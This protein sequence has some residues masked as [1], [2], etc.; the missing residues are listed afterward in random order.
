MTIELGVALVSTDISKYIE[1]VRALDRAGIGMIGCGDSQALYHE[2]FIRCALAAEHSQQARVG[3]WITNPRT[4]H[5]A[6]TAS[7]IATIDDIAPK[8]TFLGVGTGDSTVYNVGMKPASL[9]TLSDFVQTIRELH[10]N[11]KSQWQNGECYLTW[12]KRK[13]PIGMAPSGP[14]GFRLAGQIADIVWVCFGIEQDQIRLAKEYIAEG[15]A[16]AGRSLDDIDLWWMIQLSIG[17]SREE[18]IQKIKANLATSGHIIFRYGLE[19]KNVP[20]S[21]HKPIEQL[22]RDYKSIEHFKS[23]NLTD[24]LGLTEYLANRLAV[25]GTTNE[26]IDQIKK[27]DTLGANKLFFYTDTNRHKNLV[28]Q[29]TMDIMPHLND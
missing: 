8:R 5:P 6:V 7:A 28:P 23:D 26:I 2:Q 24:N 19:G 15:A 9:N 1:Q 4:R 12:A 27:L 21:L 11:G 13:I 29:L 16:I 17:D 3:T 22:T 10:I 25:A 18:A 14:K 20:A